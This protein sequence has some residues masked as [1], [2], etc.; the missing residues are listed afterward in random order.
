MYKIKL[1]VFLLFSSL[2]LRAQLSTYYDFGGLP[3]PGASTPALASP[4]LFSNDTGCLRISNGIVTF[5]ASAVGFSLFNPVCPELPNSA[6]LNFKLFP[7]PAPGMTRIFLSGSLSLS[8]NIDLLVYDYVGRIVQRKVLTEVD[9]YRGYQLSIKGL[10]AGFYVVS[11][12]H[13]GE[14]Y[15]LK[16]INTLY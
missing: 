2:I 13:N 14:S 1:T 3:L 4:I 11:L 15:N 9:F 16:L 10:P 7:N 5:S 6:V 8:K 12:V